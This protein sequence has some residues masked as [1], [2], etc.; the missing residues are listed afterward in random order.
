MRWEGGRRVSLGY[1]FSR[2]SLQSHHARPQLLPGSSPLLTVS[3]SGFQKQILPLAL[4][5]SR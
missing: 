4:S 5:G 1:F 2:P 3:L